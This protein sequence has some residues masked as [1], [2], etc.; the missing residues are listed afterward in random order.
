MTLSSFRFSCFLLVAPALCWIPGRASSQAAAPASA[1]VTSSS[2]D[3]PSLIAE[4]RSLESQIREAR[5]T[6]A[7]LSEMRL[8]LPAAWHVDARGERYEIPAEPL[9]SLL[10]T[11][12]ID[13]KQRTQRADEA[14]AWIADLRVQLDEYAARASANS[15]PARSKLDEILHRHEFGAVRPP[16]AWDLMRQRINEWLLHLLRGILSRIER[17]PIGVKLLF[18][19]VVLGVTSWIALM[20]FRF[21]NERAR[22]DEIQSIEGVVAHRSWQEWIRAAREAAARGDFREAV[23]SSYWAAIVH[24]EDSGAI[25][26]DRTRTPREYLRAV[27]QSSGDT[28]VPRAKLRESLAA[29]TSRVER[30]WYGLRPAGAQDFQE[31]MQRVQELGCRLP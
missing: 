2:Y 7:R 21:W 29:L 28:P 18:W 30:V 10:A 20:L 16:S 5:D 3:I 14:V 27:A 11:A 6:P 12:A 8:Q 26:P 23:H 24:L 9:R 25:E 1:S 13:P 17:H 15:S 31:C 19:F 4:L 22:R